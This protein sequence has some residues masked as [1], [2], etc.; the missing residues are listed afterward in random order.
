MSTDKDA[1]LMYVNPIPTTWG[2]LRSAR[3]HVCVSSL[4]DRTQKR[5]SQCLRGNPLVNWGRVRER[6]SSSVPPI[7]K[8]GKGF[9]CSLLFLIK[10]NN[11]SFVSLFSF[12]L[13]LSP[14]GVCVPTCCYLQLNSFPLSLR[15]LPPS[16]HPA[17][18]SLPNQTLLLV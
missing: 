1:L 2:E 7:Y 13:S 4:W 11:P 17:V 12:T 6:E 14:A 5:Y 8:G 3:A 10:R 9:L 15:Y 16:I 18:A